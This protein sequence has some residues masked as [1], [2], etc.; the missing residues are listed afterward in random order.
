MVT[1]GKILIGNNGS[2]FVNGYI[3]FDIY[4]LSHPETFPLRSDFMTEAPEILN[5]ATLQRTMEA[6]VYRFGMAMYTVC[7]HMV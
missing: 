1:P 7:P 2:A 4:N 5:A 6:D 3:F